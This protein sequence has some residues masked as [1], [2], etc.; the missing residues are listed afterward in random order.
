VTQDAGPLVDS[1]PRLLVVSNAA[2]DDHDTGHGHPERPSR[3]VAA[4]EGVDDARLVGGIA[5]RP[6]R[7]A[8]SDELHRIHTPAYLARLER[9]CDDGG[10]SL[11]P[12]TSAS[13]GSWETALLA[14]GAGMVAIEQ[15]EDG[16]AEAA[17]VLA[18]PPGHHAGANQAMGFCLLN[19]VAIAAAALV[20]RGERVAI[21]DWDVHHGNGTQDAF[22][23]DPR[24]MYISLHQA[25]LYP[26]TGLVTEVG[27]DDATGTTLNIPLPN[28]STGD[29]LR[30]AFDVLVTPSVKEFAPTWV[31]VSAG[32]D[33]HHA[34]PLADWSLTAG[35]YGDLARATTAC[36]PR[37]GRL[38]T[39]LEGGY[40][41]QAVRNSVG[42]VASALVGENYQPEA[43]SHGQ[44]GVADVDAIAR[45]RRAKPWNL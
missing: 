29:A 34:D 39:F 7:A 2:T 14:A 13:P 5:V 32:F 41:L 12:D 33:G 27:G 36:A 43:V 22:W 11:D 35:D 45:W 30:H 18:R 25:G 20:A 40:D 26:G 21:V 15:L 1:P 19:N 6:P 28:R 8:T 10:G 16:P 42:T 38:V 9:F 24:V 31:L 37:P 3:T 4:R 17:L 44:I 23:D